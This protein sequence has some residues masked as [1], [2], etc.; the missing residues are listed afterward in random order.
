MLLILIC[1]W[2]Q[3]RTFIELVELGV[4]AQRELRSRF[5]AQVIREI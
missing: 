3:K 5:V 1:Q 2:S 4:R